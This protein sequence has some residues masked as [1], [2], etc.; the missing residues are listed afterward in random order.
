MV[1][2]GFVLFVLS[3]GFCTVFC[4]S[5]MPPKHLAEPPSLKRALCD[6]EKSLAEVSNVLRNY[7]RRQTYSTSLP[8]QL[9]QAARI[10]LCRSKG[11]SAVLTEFLKHTSKRDGSIIDKH[12]SRLM[13][14]YS[15]CSE[16]VRSLILDGKGFSDAGAKANS[17]LDKYLK[18]FSLHAWVVQQ[19]IDQGLSPCTGAVINQM[20]SKGLAGNSR[21]GA[22]EPRKYR[23]T[24]QYLRRWR[25]R[26]QVS[27]GNIAPLEKV[28]QSVLQEKAL[29]HLTS[30][31][32][33]RFGLVSVQIS[34]ILRSKTGGHIMDPILVPRYIFHS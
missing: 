30:V 19:N 25:Q 10:I 28:S 4:C 29:K 34:G 20:I 8:N 6:V 26:W 18:E 13:D 16:E 12:V 22:R 17:M 11:N 31:D 24:L 3:A 2:L 9:D 7:R 33:T 32:Q 23:S 27:H 15:D 14:W 5:A 1:F 21:R